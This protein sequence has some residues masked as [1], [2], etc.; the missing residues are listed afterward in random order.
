MR[1]WEKSTN[2]TE[3]VLWYASGY[4]LGGLNLNHYNLIRCEFPLRVGK[5]TVRSA[6]AR[7]LSP[8]NPSSLV[9][10]PMMIFNCGRHFFIYD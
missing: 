1:R 9:D 10:R 8:N 4:R 2:V 7:E 6:V 5:G 3:T